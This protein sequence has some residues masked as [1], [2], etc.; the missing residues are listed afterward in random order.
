MTDELVSVIIPTYNRE[1]CITQSIESVLRQTYDNLEVIVVDDGSTDNTKTTVLSINDSRIRYVYQDNEG[2]CA[3][4]NHGVRVAKGRIVAFHDSDD[5]WHPEKI[6]KQLECLRT[7]DVDFVF[8]RL[9][10]TTQPLN[11]NGSVKKKIFPR[12]N[13]SQSD[14]TL[15]ELVRCNYISTQTIMGYKSVF[16]DE[17]FDVAM[18]RLQDW[19]LAIRLIQ[20][21]RMG[22]VDDVLAYQ[23][24]SADSISADNAKLLAALSLMED[25][26]Q[27]IYALTPLLQ[28]EFLRRA[29]IVFRTID[30]SYS[31]LYFRKSMRAK[32]LALTCVHR[33]YAE[34][35]W[36]F[37]L[38]FLIM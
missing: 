23:S 32:P 24:I 1:R 12:P 11:S 6:Q 37:H 38:Y 16:L 29:A 15:R 28:A 36:L 5:T 25:K 13:L 8:C 26:F 31:R 4:R 14:L 27:P 34:I 19:D 22:F 20:H 7:N 18:P 17:C 10:S 33:L 2:A 30:K 3:A 21:Y 35:I 9:E